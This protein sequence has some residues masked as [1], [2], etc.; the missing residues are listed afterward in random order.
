M[1]YFIPA[2]TWAA[3]IFI[4]S[5]MPGKNLPHIDLGDLLEADKIAHIGVYLI[6]TLLLFRGLVKQKS[7]TTKNI[8]YAIIITAGYGILLEFGQYYFFPGRYFE[9]FDIVANIIGSITSLIFLK[10]INHK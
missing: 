1:K 8:I 6:L 4:L 3:V 2:I 10:F 5:A 9:F 7:L